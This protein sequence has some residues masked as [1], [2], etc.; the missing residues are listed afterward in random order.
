MYDALSTSGA[1]VPSL[2][3]CLYAGPPIQNHLW[4]VLVRM[5]FHP[6]F[7]LQVRIKK[8]EID[9]LRFRWRASQS[10]EVEVLR[11]NRALFGLVPFPFLLG[12]V[13]ESHLETWEKSMPELVAELCNSLYVDDLINGKPTVSEA[14]QLKEGTIEIFDYTNFTLH[15]WHSHVAELEESTRGAE[16]ESTFAKQQL[17]Q[18]KK[19]SASLLGPSWHKQGD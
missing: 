11:F 3:D 15:K 2:N 8:E 18:S 7:V 14:R 12:G 1:E 5:R 19:K 9:A 4:S 6:V 13:V 16:D 10:S 17:G